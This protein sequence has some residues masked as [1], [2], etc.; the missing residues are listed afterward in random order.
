MAIKSA[1]SPIPFAGWINVK[2]NARYLA[3]IDA[4]GFGVK[5][6]PVRSQMLLVIDGQIR[7]R[8]RNVIDG[9]IE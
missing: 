3:P 4:I 2:N 1:T 7:T 5:Q 9:R 8:W 6:P